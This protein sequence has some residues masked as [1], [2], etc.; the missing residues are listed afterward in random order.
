M[1]DF[2][3]YLKN[4]F[5]I[6][7]KFKQKIKEDI[8]I[9]VNILR[10]K[11][12]FYSKKNYIESLDNFYSLFDIEKWVKEKNDKKIRENLIF[13]IYPLNVRLESTEIKA[14]ANGINVVKKKQT[15]VNIKSLKKKINKN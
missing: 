4:K 15:I 14:I 7:K 1:V 3:Y 9:S 2:N 10:K 8:E 5:K 11:G 6:I 13:S 12:K